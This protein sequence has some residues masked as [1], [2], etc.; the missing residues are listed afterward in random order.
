M[1]LIQVSSQS[2]S[3]LDNNEKQD[4][5]R[6][7]NRFN[8]VLEVPPYSEIA[9]HSGQMKIDS[10]E[11]IVLSSVGSSSSNDRPIV[12]MN[13]QESSDTYASDVLKNDNEYPSNA[14]SSPFLYNLP[15]GSYVDLA[16]CW[17]DIG[18]YLKLDPRPQFQTNYSSVG[19]QTTG[20]VVDTI[21]NNS[22]FSPSFSMV[23]NANG[24]D[25]YI[26]ASVFNTFNQKV[27]GSDTITQSVGG[28]VLKT[29]ASAG[30][31]VN[32]SMF[33]T[34]SN[35]IHNANGSL[36]VEG[37]L[38]KAESTTNGS[39]QMLIGIKRWGNPS[40]S[41]GWS[42]MFE[43]SL[44]L[45]QFNKDFFDEYPDQKYIPYAMMRN[46]FV[47][48]GYSLPQASTCEFAF[49]IT[50]K[51]VSISLVNMDDETPP[52]FTFDMEQD[53][54][55]ILKYEKGR[56]TADGFDRPRCIIIATGD[57]I[58]SEIYEIPYSK[59]LDPA[60]DLTEWSDVG[61]KILK[62]SLI[63]TDGA[64][65]SK[66]ILNGNVV[67]F[68]F[69]AVAVTLQDP[70]G[71]IT[72]VE[73]K[74]Q[75]SDVVF[76]LQVF[77]VITRGGSTSESGFLG[78]GY[79][80]C[81]E[82]SPVIDYGRQYTDVVAYKA[83]KQMIP[84]EI[85]NYEF[86]R[87]TPKCYY[88]LDETTLLSVS[89]GATEDSMTG[90][91]LIEQLP[92]I[93]FGSSTLGNAKGSKIIPNVDT[94]IGSPTSLDMS[95]A[96]EYETFT[97]DYTSTGLENPFLKGIYIRLKN[98]TNRSTFGSI[99]AV[100]TDKLI[101]VINRYDSTNQVSGLTDFPLYSFTEYDRLYIALNNPTPLFLSQ[102]DFEIVDR[103]GDVIREIDNTTLV[104]HLRPAQYR[105]LYGYKRSEKM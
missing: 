69:N 85:Y 26:D 99:N 91:D 102:L 48:S 8:G 79:S 18:E 86:A 14:T 80:V 89:G 21:I 81:G 61:N 82:Q 65:T 22:K 105:D 92:F 56:M 100:D 2:R 4:G 11:G 98:L 37:F 27:E 62:S 68:E 96:D 23:S 6:F 63:D 60:S 38:N 97:A 15:K 25:E 67:T 44:N 9:V 101:A 13:F 66:I 31:G 19:E 10:G 36:S 39:N 87:I 33:Y 78:V 64:G 28:N 93:Y 57:K 42:D 88:P 83:N 103:T 104:L 72:D 84:A 70:T 49:H 59:E 58:V 71:I 46:M 75:L 7:S 54:C 17:K 94:L 76:P 74:D 30:R 50:K 43:A 34:D 3:E 77:G 73:L 47:T 12:R 40:N 32:P 51:V 95:T 20:L 55:N 24:G 41:Q 29:S 90:D 1:S 16:S 5:F 45:T 53:V 52:T 35:G